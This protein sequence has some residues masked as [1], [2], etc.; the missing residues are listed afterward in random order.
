MSFG[1]E[2]AEAEV[3]AQAVLR[4]VAGRLRPDRARRR[5]RRRRRQQTM[6]V[7]DEKGDH[8]V[9]NGSK[10]FITNAGYADTFIIF[11]MTDKSRGQ[12]TASPPSSWS[13][14]LPRLLRRQ[15]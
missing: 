1:T 7:L 2:A 13:S 12:P 9:L 11:A 6:A 5:H 14:D 15:T 3:P 10:I 8:Y 4:R